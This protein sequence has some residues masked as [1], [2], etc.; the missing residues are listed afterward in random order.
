MSNP[1]IECLSLSKQYSRNNQRFSA[2][3]D[4]SLKINRNEAFLIKGRSGAGKSTL[5]NLMCG[6]VRP[7]GGKV[8]INGICITDLP[9][10]SLSNVLL[11]DIGIIFQSFNLLPTYNIYENIEIALVPKKLNREMVQGII[12]SYLEQFDLKDKAHLLPSEL[13]VGQQQKVAIIRT[14][15]KEPSVIFADEPTGSVDEISASEILEHL[16]NLKMHK[17]VTLVMA[18][19]GNIPDKIADRII[20]IEN[21]RIKK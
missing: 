5:L 11:N 8:F 14:L 7:T 21:G 4:I 9:N 3:D 6:L 12:I 15:V 2:I 19:H 13:S 10:D 18:S 17:Q 1:Y 16:I 20:E